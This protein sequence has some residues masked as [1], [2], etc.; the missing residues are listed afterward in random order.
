MVTVPVLGDTLRLSLDP[1]FQEWGL[2]LLDDLPLVE[3][4]G[5]APVAYRLA[6]SAIG[7]GPRVHPSAVVSP[8]AN[9][10]DDVVIGPGC[11]VCEY[12]TV[13]DRSVLSAGVHVGY[14]CEVN[15]SVIAA[16]TSLGH[17][18]G[19]G[20]SVV[21]RACHLSSSLTVA[22]CDLWSPDMLHP[23][24]PISITMADGT[25]VETGKPKWGA[26]IGDG[27]RTAVNVTL[28][29]GAVIGADCV[30]YGEVAVAC[31]EIPSRS[32]LRPTHRYHVEPRRDLA[33]LTPLLVRGE[34]P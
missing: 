20:H 11:R 12:S 32:V 31:T 18:V 3:I 2:G 5:I 34:R 4:G 27:V 14:G 28:G 22:V 17:R 7:S 16:G 1:L 25:L 30:L 21:G 6:A 9:I 8:L 24:R 29:P 19:L 13:R 26:V 23:S 15:R 10:A 33:P